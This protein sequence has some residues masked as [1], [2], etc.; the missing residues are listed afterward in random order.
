MRTSTSNKS[1]ANRFCKSLSNKTKSLGTASRQRK[2]STWSS[3]LAAISLVKCTKTSFVSHWSSVCLNQ[4]A[5]LRQ[6]SATSK[7]TRL[8]GNKFHSP[9]WP[10]SNPSKA[11]QPSLVNGVI[12]ESQFL[13]TF[14]VATWAASLRKPSKKLP[15]KCS[16]RTGVITLSGA[17]SLN[18][19]RVPVSG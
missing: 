18:T 4:F 11:R 8:Q 5:V 13:Q 3:H 15:M 19:I 2:C 14:A 17:G 1:L 10:I 6:Q 9:V 12:G 7:S 16:C